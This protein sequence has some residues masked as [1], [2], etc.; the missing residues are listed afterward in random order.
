MLMNMVS[1]IVGKVDELVFGGNKKLV[2][3]IMGL[4]P[5]VGIG[6]SGEETQVLSGLGEELVSCR[7]LV[8]GD[9]VGVK[10]SLKV[11]IG[12][13]RERGLLGLLVLLVEVSRENVVLLTKNVLGLIDVLRSLLNELVVGALGG[14]SLLRE[15]ILKL[16]GVP[17]LEKGVPLRASSISVSVHKLEK[18]VLGGTLGSLNLSRLQERAQ[19]GFG[20]EL[21]GLLEGLV[22]KVL[23]SLDERN[24]ILLLVSGFG[25]LVVVVEE[26]SVSSDD[27]QDLILL[28]VLGN[29][30]SVGVSPVL[31]LGVGPVVEDVLPNLASLV[32]DILLGD[33]EGLL[34]VISSLLTLNVKGSGIL[35]DGSNQ[36]VSLGALGDRNSSL[37]EPLLEIRI[38]PGVV[39]PVGGV[40]RLGRSTGDTSGF[41]NLLVVLLDILDEL[42]SGSSRGNNNLG[43]LEQVVE[44]LVGPG[45][46]GPGPEVNIV[47]DVIGQLGG[48]GPGSG[49]GLVGLVLEVAERLLPVG[50]EL[51]DVDAELLGKIGGGGLVK[52]RG[53]VVPVDS[54]LL[55]ESVSV[56][57]FGHG[58]AIVFQQRSE[59]LRRPGADLVVTASVRRGHQ[60]DADE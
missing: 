6:S 23:G 27:G 14:L 12:P 9:T 50:G 33:V 25:I 24:M 54:D 19:S 52:G 21:G 8:G 51:L 43:R 31:E 28:R 53:E 58:H 2:D 30:D 35:S 40:R 59:I 44:L 13:L 10:V 38:G 60:Q 7:A 32:E 17:R 1:N 20:P 48:L 39:E 47:V 41:G 49:P 15:P 42:T 34:E 46:E 37:V 56:A 26:L 29:R 45:V 11:R 16:L 4:D 55:K 5:N 18:I 57:L 22:S 36:L 3:T